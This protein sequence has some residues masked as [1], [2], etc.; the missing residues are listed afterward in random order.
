[1]TA[2]RITISEP[3]EDIR[4]I[5]ENCWEKL[6]SQVGSCTKCALYS[7]RT[8]PVLGEGSRNSFVMF[9]G[10]APG[11]DEDKEG[12]PFIG[13]AGKL[14][15]K[16]FEAAGIDRKEVYITNVVKCRPPENRTP[17]IEE[18]LAC[19]KYLETQIALINPDII[20][21]LGSTP[22]KWFLKSTEGITKLRGK[23]FKWRGIDLM[24]MFHPSYLLR[25]QSRKPG[26]PKDVTWKDI[27][28]VK[29]YLDVCRNRKDGS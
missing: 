7:E 8:Q 5:I 26:S 17:A 27:Q 25:N 2:D 12:K 10:E 19:S 4:N 18:M 13:K 23:W 29:R 14:L 28:E 24:P 16:I 9:V 11:A 22:T 3:S 20:V 1:M 21:C 15:T 6:D